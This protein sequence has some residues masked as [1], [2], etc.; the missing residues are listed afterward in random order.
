MIAKLLFPLRKQKIYASSVSCILNQR[1]L[2][3]SS[4]RNNRQ[5]PR[6]GQWQCFGILMGLVIANLKELNLTDRDSSNSL[7]DGGKGRILTTTFVSDAV[8]KASPAV[9]NIK[10]RAGYFAMAAGSGFIISKDGFVVTNAH[11]VAGAH[12]SVEITMANGAKRIGKVHSV[13]TTSDIALVQIQNAYKYDLPTLPF[14]KSAK[15]KPGEFVVAIGS[16][17]GLSN[18]VSLGIVSAIARYGGEIGAR[19]KSFY[20]QT[21][22]AIN[23]G[24][25]G[26]PLINIDGEVVGINTMKVIS[27]NVEGI[28][29]ASKYFLLTIYYNLS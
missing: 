15:L 27:S 8:E 25:S 7:C 11:V 5:S 29:F 21:D 14:G 18:S 20:I 23:S 9:V 17:M 4:V 16:P 1:F 26:G 13:D 10:S 2:H 3:V 28:S 6:I 24:N 12:D 22:T 19:K